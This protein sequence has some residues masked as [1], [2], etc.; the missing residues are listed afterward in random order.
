VFDFL[1][2]HVLSI[3]AMR[4]AGGIDTPAADHRQ[5]A[6]Q[7]LPRAIT[8]R[9]AST[10]DQVFLSSAARVLPAPLPV[11]PNEPAET[12]NR[13]RD[14]LRRLR[15]LGRRFGRS[16][17]RDRDLDEHNASNPPPGGRRF[18]GWA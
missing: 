10:D 3:A 15:D 9:A 8:S 12:G 11:K 13:V 17:R 2:N 6:E 5:A 14:A 7:G 18:D 16:E 1:G 4:R